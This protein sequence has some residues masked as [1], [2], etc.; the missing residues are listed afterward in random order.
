MDHDWMFE[1]PDVFFDHLL[2]LDLKV[3]AG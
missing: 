3:L 1:Q 2:D